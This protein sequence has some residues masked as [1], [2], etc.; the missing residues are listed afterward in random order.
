M[1]SDRD[2]GSD[3]SGLG[4]GVGDFGISNN[5]RTTRGGGMGTEKFVEN[6]SHH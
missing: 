2:S 3:D 1:G 4:G 6:I 5:G